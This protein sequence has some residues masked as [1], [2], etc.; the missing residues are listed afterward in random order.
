M[1]FCKGHTTRAVENLPRYLTWRC[2]LATGYGEIAA[3]LARRGA[4]PCVLT[5]TDIRVGQWEIVRRMGK[6]TWERTVR[7]LESLARLSCGSS[8][9]VPDKHVSISEARQQVDTPATRVAL[10]ALTSDD[11]SVLTLDP[12]IKFQLLDAAV[13]LGNA[14]AVATLA[15]HCARYGPTTWQGT[16][17]MA[18]HRKVLEVTDVKEGRAFLFAATETELTEPYVVEA[19][20]CAG[21]DLSSVTLPVRATENG[22]VDVNLL[23]VAVLSANTKVALAL[24]SAGVKPMMLLNDG[25]MFLSTAGGARPVHVNMV[26]L[27][28][29]IA[30]GIDLRCLRVDLVRPQQEAVCEI[31]LGSPFTC[32][33][34]KNPFSVEWLISTA[35][36]KS[37]SLLDAAI[38]L[39]QKECAI[40]LAKHG[41]VASACIAVEP[42]GTLGKA[43]CRDCSITGSISMNSPKKCKHAA[44]AALRQGYWSA[45]ASLQPVLHQWSAQCCKTRFL[46]AH[47]PAM[48]EQRI[49]A[50]AADLPLM[51]FF[52]ITEPFAELQPAGGG[53]PTEIGYAYAAQRGVKLTPCCWLERAQPPVEAP[54]TRH[55]QGCWLERAEPPVEAPTT[56]HDQANDVDAGEGPGDGHEEEFDLIQPQPGNVSVFSISDVLL[57][58]AGVSRPLVPVTYGE[59]TEPQWRELGTDH[60]RTSSLFISL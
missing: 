36:R 17:L 23:D 49:I 27:Q 25:T 56:R 31:G 21:A 4:R 16:E 39:G 24:S 32:R 57:A 13:L 59:V 47:M 9:C 43:C 28:L 50:F 8:E 29:A 55:D 48:V 42:M 10:T 3:E 1:P 35:N 40:F 38:L 2:A 44:M 34:C 53:W 6:Q 5:P 18:V 33:R 45:C 54:T 20:V 22:T 60:V 30:C 58:W 19:A 52:G 46:D 7:S 11:V 37:L 26:A 14:R 15:K 51:A 41:V 12:R